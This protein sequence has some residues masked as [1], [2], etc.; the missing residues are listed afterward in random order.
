MSEQGR[1]FSF[2]DGPSYVGPGE[3]T[4]AHRCG[5]CGAREYIKI[6]GDRLGYICAFGCDPAICPHPDPLLG[7]ECPHCGTEDLFECHG[8]HKNTD[9]GCEFCKRCND[10]GG[11]M[12]DDEVMD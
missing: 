1:T 4:D 10:C 11:C 5:V 7:D 2:E 3:G 9:R 6:R 12:D 8:C